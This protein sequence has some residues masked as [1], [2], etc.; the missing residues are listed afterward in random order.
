MTNDERIREKLLEAIRALA[1]ILPLL[2]APPSGPQLA[3]WVNEALSDRA[4]DLACGSEVKKICRLRQFKR[5]NR[6]KTRE[7]YS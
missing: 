5:R 1:E 7:R 6:K 2:A 4:R 3:L